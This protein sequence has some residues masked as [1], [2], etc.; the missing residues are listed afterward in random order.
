[1]EGFK[2]L[3]SSLDSVKLHIY[4]DDTDAAG[5]VDHANYLKYLERARTEYFSERG[6]LVAKLA[7]AGCVF[8]VVRIVVHLYVSLRAALRSDCPLI[9]LLPDMETNPACLHQI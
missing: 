2:L 5:S 4:Y 7:A 1:M 8:T 6:P 3:T 9:F